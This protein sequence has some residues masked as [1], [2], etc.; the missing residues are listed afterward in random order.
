MDGWRPLIEK[1]LRPHPS[2][3]D[4]AG[5]R[6]ARLA[7]GL[8]LLLLPLLFLAFLFPDEQDG[9][10][11]SGHRLT[12][13]ALVGILASYALIRGGHVA[14]GV[15]VAIA[16]IEAALAVSVGNAD[17]STTATL[18]LTFFVVPI[19]MAGILLPAGG[20]AAVAAGTLAVTLVLEPLVQG[21]GF[22][23]PP[24]QHALTLAL[25]LVAVSTLA[26]A[27]ASMAGRQAHELEQS[28]ELLRQVTEN[29]PEVMFLVAADGSRMLYAS[30]AYETVVGRRVEQAMAD[31]QDWLKAVH[32][33]DLPKVQASLAA[34]ES[35][36]DYRVVHPSGKVKEIHA[37][38]FPV[39]GPDGRPVSLVGIAE[40]VTEARRAQ[41]QIREAQRQR[42]HLLQQLAHD[43]ATPLTPV[44]LQL[45]ILQGLVGPEGAQNMAVLRRNVEHL[46]R[47]VADVK[48]V[49][50]LEMGG[51]K[52]E[53]RE[54]DLVS[55]ARQAVE[56]LQL[57]AAERR[58]AVQL[59]API[60]L[61]V[62]ADPG[63]LT[64]ALYN[65]VGNALKFTPAEG[66]ITVTIAKEGGEARV[67]VRDTGPG[68]RPDQLAKLF[69]PFS[70]VHDGNAIKRPEDKGSGLGLYISKGIA[71]AH[72]GRMA[73]RSA[74]PGLGSTF[75]FFLPLDGPP[76][77][78]V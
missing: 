33:D 78:P 16:T 41:E 21:H 66:T 42:I 14:L 24:D 56:T 43:L 53:P 40:D 17:D 12:T 52:V 7:A 37:R 13:L 26:V 25:L 51:L 15:V 18:V 3:H 77:G 48:D 34:R 68:L 9:P 44:K 31:P 55:L 59:E 20:A 69:K 5:Q 2:I 19:A 71:E 36:L 39:V 1:A 29:I 30:P 65:L 6:R 64:Q 11:L 23:L 72:G 27:S 10:F 58:V 38:T 54:V 63:R 76:N 67:D 62:S 28:R 73:A 45:R 4:T 60:A 35:E 8:L 50:R 57:P 46:E 32:P 22:T 49:A 74:G 61:S 70:Q 47:L 75:T